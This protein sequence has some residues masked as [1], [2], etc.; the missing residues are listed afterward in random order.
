M[1]TSISRRRRTFITLTDM[2]IFEPTHVGH[3]VK[4][5][6]KQGGIQNISI[7]SMIVKR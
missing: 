7:A 4:I 2:Q 5:A 3:V 1:A 6:P